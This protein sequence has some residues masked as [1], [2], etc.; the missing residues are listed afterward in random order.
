MT[1]EKE[2]EKKGE[3]KKAKKLVLGMMKSKLTS[4]EIA[5]HPDRDFITTP[6]P[7]RE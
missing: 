7:K 4:E 1:A 3:S 2:L 5:H 6:S